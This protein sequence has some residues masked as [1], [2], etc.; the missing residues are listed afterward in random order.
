MKNKNWTNKN[1]YYQIAMNEDLGCRCGEY[2]FEVK[3]NE[4]NTVKGF[5]RNVSTIIGGGFSCGSS[6]IY[7]GGSPFI[8]RYNVIFKIG[9]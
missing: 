3:N 5:F 1:G 9:K 7:V 2:N 6:N 8:I 4:W